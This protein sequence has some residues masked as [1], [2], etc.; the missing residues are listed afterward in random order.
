MSKRTP[1]L[2]MTLGAGALV[3]VSV[4]GA[5][6]QLQT[7]GQQACLN[8]VNKDGAAVAKTQGKESLACVKG[9]GK[10]TLSGTAQ[11]CLTADVKG[12]VAK[13]KSK[14]TAHATKSCTA[15]PSFGFTSA[16]TANTAAQQAALDLVADVYG[17]NLDAAIVSCASSKA[18][19]ACQQKVSKGVE[20][21]AAVKLATFVACKKAALKGGANSSAALAACVN[22]GGTVGSIAADS[23][24]KI[25][26]VI[27]KLNADI[28]KAC[29]T[30]GVTTGAFPGDCTGL[31]GATLGTCLDAQVECRVCQTINEM[32][33]IFVNC[34]G[35]DNGILD[36]SCASGAGPTPTP[37]TTATPTP[38]PTVTY[39]P[40]QIY[41]G[42]ISKTTGLW[43]YDGV[44]G[45]TGGALE[46][47]DHFPGS[48]LCTFAELEA[49]E[50]AGQLVGAVDVD[51]L[52]VSAFWAVIPGADPNIQ[53]VSI[54]GSVLW[55]YG[56]AHTLS[57]GAFATLNNGTGALTS[58][59]TTA[60]NG[61]SNNG[62]ACSSGSSCPGGRCGGP[63][64]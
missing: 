30:P 63:T 19:C 24:G 12:K 3:L 60:C 22:D 31:T 41:V 33:G 56:T 13:A 37:T 16:A 51:A 46:C 44:N 43:N 40:G 61:G 1:I 35:F 27:A 21:I 53:C 14:T 8:A 28:T 10:G 25:G 49:A 57:D 47:N 48:H 7:S 32:D 59:Q 50:A 52:A 9:A 58:V 5:W 54:S 11:A 62:G 64:V 20:A 38:M 6:A 17:A 39:A 23:K 34:D 15:A 36:A 26:K 18:G 2:S 42:A 4:L 45:Q 55:F 29:D